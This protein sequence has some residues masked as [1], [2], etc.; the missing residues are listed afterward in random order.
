M[1]DKF[2]SFRKIRWWFNQWRDLQK[3]W[4][5][6]G[7]STLEDHSRVAMAFLREEEK[8]RK[9][10]FE[11]FAIVL[12]SWEMLF[13]DEEMYRVIN[14]SLL[15]NCLPIS[16]WTLKLS[17]KLT[18]SFFGKMELIVGSYALTL[19]LFYFGPIILWPEITL[20][21]NTMFRVICDPKLT[22]ALA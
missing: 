22:H 2:D 14:L 18:L 21:H 16:K 1:P 12:Y 11:P 3:K 5:Q 6:V 17:Q 7:L 10:F 4:E 20:N 13:R 9:S 19:S 8:I 15:K